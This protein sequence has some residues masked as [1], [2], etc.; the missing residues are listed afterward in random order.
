MLMYFF[1]GVEYLKKK[2]CCPF[3]GFNCS[4]HFLK[5]S[6]AYVWLLEGHKGVG[7][8]GLAAAWTWVR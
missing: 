8:L 4:L 3:C 7:A 2:V 5:T 6:A 1:F